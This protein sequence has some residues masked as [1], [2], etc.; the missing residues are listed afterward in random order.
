MSVFIVLDVLFLRGQAVYSYVRCWGAGHPVPPP[1][2]LN[3]PVPGTYI[4]I[5]HVKMRYMTPMHAFI[6]K[7]GICNLYNIHMVLLL[8]QC[9][10]LIIHMYFTKIVIQ[11]LSTRHISHR[12]VIITLQCR[13]T[14]YI[15]H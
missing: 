12:D 14:V 8:D 2:R 1:P 9:H 4:Y 13:N 11:T 7:V 6:L 15:S 3:L 10:N 5:V